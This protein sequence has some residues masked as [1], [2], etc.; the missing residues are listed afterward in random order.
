MVAAAGIGARLVSRLP[1][2]YVPLLGIPMLQRTLAIIDSCPRVDAM[3][4]VVNEQ[5]VEYCRGEIKAE[6]IGKVVGVASGGQE[7]LSRSAMACG[8]SL[9]QAFG[10]SS[11]CMT[12][13]GLW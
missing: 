6:R 7:R 1:K 12:A 13:R 11:A 9:K 2:Q 4:V 8:S 10:I 3:V 5:D